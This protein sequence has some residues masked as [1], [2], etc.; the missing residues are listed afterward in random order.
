MPS[1][2]VRRRSSRWATFEINNTALRQALK[3]SLTVL[4]EGI[5]AKG[6]LLGSKPSEGFYVKCD[7]INN[8]QAVADTRR[9]VLNLARWLGARAAVPC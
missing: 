4:L 3:H 9:Y 6:G 7:E 8:P 1:F 2:V 5:W